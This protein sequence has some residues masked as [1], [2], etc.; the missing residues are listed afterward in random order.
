MYR[1]PSIHKVTNLFKHTNLKIAFHPTNTIYRQLPQKP[2][3]PN[4]S[5][6]Y[7]LKCNTCNSAYIGQ[8][9]GLITIWHREHHHYIRNN[10]PTLVYAM[11]VLDNRHG[12]GTAD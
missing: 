9:D 10:N 12:F 5:G 1:S 3:D 8:S 4:P 6:I 7:Q 11:H 2:K